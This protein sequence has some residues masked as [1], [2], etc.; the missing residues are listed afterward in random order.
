MLPDSAAYNM[1]LPLRLEGE[2]DAA[3]LEVHNHS[4]FPWLFTKDS[5]INCGWC[6]LLVF[7]HMG[8]VLCSANLNLP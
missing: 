8:Y 2:P 5:E 4:S 6:S 3:A 1:S 7:N